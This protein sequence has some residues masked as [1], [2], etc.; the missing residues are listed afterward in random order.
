MTDALNNPTAFFSDKDRAAKLFAVIETQLRN[1]RQQVLTQLGYIKDDLRMKVPQT[2]TK[3]DP[4]VVPADPEGQK[5]MFT[6][7]GSTIG[8]LQDPNATVYLQMP[9]GRIDAF[10]PL[11]L[12][13]LIQK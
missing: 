9:N 3:V 7:L 13:G 6:Y 10:N 8:T 4:F 1:S 12:R 2:G 5:R 11:Q